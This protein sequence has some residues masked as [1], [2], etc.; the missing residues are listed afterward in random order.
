MKRWIGLLGALALMV[1]GSAQAQNTIKIGALFETSGFLAFLGNQGLEGANLAVEEIN[2]AGGINGQKIE[3]INFNTESDETKAVIGVKKLLERDKVV[4]LIGAMNSGST[5][6]I[7]DIIQRAE[8]PIISNGASRALSTPVSEKKWIFQAPLTDVLVINVLIDHFKKMGISKIALNN[9]D[10]GFAT[11]GM[12]QW[13]KIAPQ[14]GIDIVIQQTYG[15]GDADMTPQLTNIRAK[16][17]VQAV[18]QWGTG[19]GQAIVAKNY[20]QLGI[21]KPLYYSHA[22]SDPNLIKLGGNAANGI[23]FPTSKIAV[24]DDLPDS[25]PQKKVTANFVKK[26]NA[27]YGRGPATFAG[28]GYDSMMMLAAAIRR[29]GGPDFC[30][31]PRCIRANHELSGRHLRLHVFVDGPLRCQ[32]RRRRFASDQGRQSPLVQ[33]VTW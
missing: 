27:K 3:L 5:F 12:K 9:A 14:R 28:N 13:Q 16:S 7:I 22:A 11:S 23:I 25:D 24:V 2:A 33:I 21:D 17:E 18:V 26:F 6:S 20:R 29:A 8:I 1:G 31:D 15:N 30:Q 19:K 32:A 4:A 10:S